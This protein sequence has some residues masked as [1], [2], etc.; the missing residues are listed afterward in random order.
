MMRRY[1]HP[2]EERCIKAA[3][4][5]IKE[6]VNFLDDVPDVMDKLKDEN[7]DLKAQVATLTA[8]IE[9]LRE[10]K[11]IEDDERINGWGVLSD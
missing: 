5:E 8:Q 10:E 2:D 11:A 4:E 1:H 9:E 3:L 6:A 7:V